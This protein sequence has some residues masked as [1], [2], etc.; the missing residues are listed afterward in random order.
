M[1]L[2][3]ELLSRGWLSAPLALLALNRFEARR[4]RLGQI[5]LCEGLLEIGPLL[6][7]L[8]QQMEDA[9]NG[10]R[11]LFGE[12]ARALGYLAEEEVDQLLQLQ[13]SSSPA[14]DEIL[15]D[16]GVLEEDLIAVQRGAPPCDDAQRS[17]TSIATSS[18][19]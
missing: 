5:A 1:A 10:R 16:I 11:R 6:H 13:T 2:P 4:I 8:D 19:R 7:I 18:S 17:S 12:T 9:E 14:L 15:R 3:R